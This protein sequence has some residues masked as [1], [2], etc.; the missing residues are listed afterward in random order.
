MPP[1]LSVQR[2]SLKKLER[3]YSGTDATVSKSHYLLDG[4]DVGP[5]LVGISPC[6]TSIMEKFSGNYALFATAWRY[7]NALQVTVEI[8]LFSNMI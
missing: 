2:L 3:A 8:Y 5:L 7:D 6:T 4:Q 1:L